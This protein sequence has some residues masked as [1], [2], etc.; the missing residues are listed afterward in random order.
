MVRIKEEKEEIVEVSTLD[1]TFIM[2]NLLIDSLRSLASKV[3]AKELPG[4]CSTCNIQFTN[5]NV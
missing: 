5:Y 1:T 2:Y 3:Y 4:P